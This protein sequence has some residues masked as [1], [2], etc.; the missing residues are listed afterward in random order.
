MGHILLADPIL[1]ERLLLRIPQLEDAE[2][3]NEAVTESIEDL[4]PWM[5]WAQSAPTLEE[6]QQVCRSMNERAVAGTDNVIFG[7]DRKTG[8][9]VLSTGLHPRHPDSS[10]LEIGYWCRSS[11]HGHGYVTEAVRA[12]TPLALAMGAPLVIIRCD[13]RNVKSQAVAL[14][15]GYRLAVEKL[16]EDPLGGDRRMNWYVFDPR[17]QAQS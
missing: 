2:Q 12:L 10:A 13:V 5:P 16:E 8:E 17:E 1:T 11:K 6:S 15:C 14:R 4:R 9:L 7:F 3:L